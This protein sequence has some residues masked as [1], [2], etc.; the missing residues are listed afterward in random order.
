MFW[1]QVRQQVPVFGHRRSTRAQP[2]PFCLRHRLAAE[3]IFA[4]ESRGLEPCLNLAQSFH[5]QLIL[6]AIRDG[7]GE[8]DHEPKP[9]LQVVQLGLREQPFP[10]QIGCCQTTQGNPSASRTSRSEALSAVSSNW[11]GLVRRP[12]LRY[13]NPG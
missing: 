8:C 13:A 7:S 9:V 5:R 10:V 1:T 6:V 2:A 4:H 11:A 12:D 3:R